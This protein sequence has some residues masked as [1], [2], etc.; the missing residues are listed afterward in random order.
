MPKHANTLKRVKTN[1][2]SNLAPERAMRYPAIIL[3][4]L[5]FYND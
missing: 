4:G 1:P 5:Y 2:N 3:E